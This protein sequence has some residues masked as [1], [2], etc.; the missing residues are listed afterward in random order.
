MDSSPS[1][2]SA[3]EKPAVRNTPVPAPAAEASSSSSSE[4]LP[5]VNSILERPSPVA[6]PP[7]PGAGKPAGGSAVKPT[8]GAVTSDKPTVIEF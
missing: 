6:P 4:V 7:K 5:A 2:Q 3:T 1:V 8:A